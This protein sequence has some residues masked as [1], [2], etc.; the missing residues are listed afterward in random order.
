MAENLENVNIPHGETNHRS[1]KEPMG[2]RR[3]TNPRSRWTTGSVMT[4]REGGPSTRTTRSQRTQPNGTNAQNQP[5]PGVRRPQGRPRGSQTRRQEDA[6][7][8]QPR[9]NEISPKN[10]NEQP[11]GRKPETDEREISHDNEEDLGTQSGERRSPARNHQRSSQTHRVRTRI[12]PNGGNTTNCTQ[13]ER[14]EHE[15]ASVTL[16]RSRTH[17]QS[18]RRG[19][20]TQ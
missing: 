14:T 6:W 5:K 11:D 3:S 2:S 15:E 13:G 16:R 17:S 8:E 4:Q 20:S 7:E 1:G 10:Q 18:T 9:E 12:D 19:K